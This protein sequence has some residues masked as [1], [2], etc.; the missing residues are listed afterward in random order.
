[1]VGSTSWEG[2]RCQNERKWEKVPFPYCRQRPS[3]T[4]Y[5]PGVQMLL[6]IYTLPNPALNKCCICPQI[7]WE[8][9]LLTFTKRCWTS[10]LGNPSQG[11]TYTFY[12]PTELPWH[13]A[14][15]YLK[16]SRISAA[17]YFLLPWWNI[18]DWT[19]YKENSLAGHS[20]LQP[21]TWKTTAERYI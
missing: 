2:T 15:S 8:S 10:R 4:S 7:H 11:S 20:N 9:G 21:R 12:W 17:V 13:R 19:A 14:P 18:W 1:M 3:L 16:A 5:L 6:S